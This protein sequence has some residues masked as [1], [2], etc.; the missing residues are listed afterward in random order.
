MIKI[1]LLA[2]ASCATLHRNV[3]EN[4]HDLCQTGESVACDDATQRLAKYV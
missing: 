1:P 2:L 4:Y 3:V